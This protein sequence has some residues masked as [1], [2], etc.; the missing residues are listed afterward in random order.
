MIQLRLTREVKLDVGKDRV[1]ERCSAGWLVNRLAKAPS[2]GIASLHKMHP[3][4]EREH[5]A[6]PPDLTRD[7]A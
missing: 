7:K 4:T 1:Q 5:I 3:A 2:S 6:P